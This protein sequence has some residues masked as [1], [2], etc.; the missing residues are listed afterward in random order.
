MEEVEVEDGCSNDYIDEDG[1]C[2][3][4]VDIGCDPGVGGSCW[5][6]TSSRKKINHH[7]KINEI[8][9]HAKGLSNN[10]WESN[11]L[12]SNEGCDSDSI[13]EETCGKFPTFCMPKSMTEYE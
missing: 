2:L 9:K 10:E 1:D 11:E 8:K 6:S 12:V 3:I 7:E 5:T 4:D 13:E